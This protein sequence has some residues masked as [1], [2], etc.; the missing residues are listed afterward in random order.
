MVEGKVKLGFGG[1]KLIFGGLK[2]IEVGFWM[3]VG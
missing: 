2:L 3:F 1:L